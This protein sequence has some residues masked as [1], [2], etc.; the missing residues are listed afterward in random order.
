MLTLEGK[1]CIITGAA[2]GIGEQTAIIFDSLGAKVLAL[3]IDGERGR[4]LQKNS[5]SGR[6]TFKRI[7][8][9]NRAQL[10]EF[11]RWAEKNLERVDA[12]INN[13]I[14]PR[15]NSVLDA[16][17]EEWDDEI[18]LS[19]TASFLLSRLAAKKMIAK[20]VRGK[21][22]LISAVQAWIPLHS[23][24]SYSVVKGGMISMAKSLA[25]D[26]G[27]HGISVTA[28]MPGPIYTS[29]GSGVEDAPPSLDRKAATLLGRMGRRAEVANLLAFLASDLNSFMTGNTILIDGGRSI[30]RKPDPDEV[31]NGFLKD[32]KSDHHS[33]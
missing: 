7:D 27:A 29:L 3:D 25:V 13:A 10:R 26:L 21:I 19:L 14:V 18:A 6:I 28:V 16:S 4:R 2:S 22:I 33:G 20:K 9:T 32:P 23:S 5:R 24:F 30:S 15:R 12:L 17:L 8:L 1:T 31:A 11:D